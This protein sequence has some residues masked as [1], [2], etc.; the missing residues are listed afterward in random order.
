VLVTNIVAI[1]FVANVMN[2]SGRNLVNFLNVTDFLNMLYTYYCLPKNKYF[3]LPEQPITQT[4]T[5]IKNYLI[6]YSR[7]SLCTAELLGLL[8]GLSILSFIDNK[9]H[10]LKLL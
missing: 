7:S 10:F 9:T 6:F 3:I 5:T 1:F 4:F 8:Y 2:K